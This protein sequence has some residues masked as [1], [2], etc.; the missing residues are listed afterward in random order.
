[1]GDCDQPAFGALEFAKTPEHK[2]GRGRA[3][4]RNCPPVEGNATNV[5]GGS[6]PRVSWSAGDAAQSLATGGPLATEPVPADLEIWSAGDQKLI[7]AANPS[8]RIRR[9]HEFLAPRGP[10]FLGF[11][12]VR[13][14]P[15]TRAG[16]QSEPQKSSKII[17]NS[18][19]QF[20]SGRHFE[21]FLRTKKSRI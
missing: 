2:E 12:R 6:P 20:I 14:R 17:K 11:F 4:K 15:E 8:V 18:H 21:Y 5:G 1:M 3:N 9:L 13:R 10:D 7:Q 19:S 16:G